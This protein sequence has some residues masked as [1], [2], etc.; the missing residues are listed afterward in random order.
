M[1]P[2]QAYAQYRE[3]EDRVREAIKEGLRRTNQENNSPSD[4]L[5]AVF[6]L[7]DVMTALGSESSK[8]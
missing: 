5:R 7:D 6:I 3:L 1:T 8:S 2:D 4:E